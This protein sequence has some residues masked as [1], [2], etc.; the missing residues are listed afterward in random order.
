MSRKLKGRFPTGVR[1][2]VGCREEK[3][4]GDGVKLC[5]QCFMGLWECV[6]HYAVFREK[7]KGGERKGSRWTGAETSIGK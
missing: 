3:T 6:R 2:I 4:W 7:T 1:P 5:L